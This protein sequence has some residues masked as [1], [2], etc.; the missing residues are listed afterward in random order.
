MV[1]TRAFLPR[2]SADL[3]VHTGDVTLDGAN[4]EGDFAM[5]AT[6]MA[7]MPAPLRVVPGN[8]DVG[9][10]GSAT[11]KPD[12]ARIARHER[13]FGATPW[14]EDR[15]GWR[16]LG[17]SSQ[18]IGAGAGPPARRADPASAR[19]PA[20][21]KVRRLVPEWPLSRV[22]ASLLGKGGEFAA[23]PALRHADH[24]RGAGAAAEADPRAR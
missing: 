1:S 18:V 6:A 24:P 19:T 13:H 3:I 23:V 22:M 15:P 8:H 9:D 2:L 20:R 5:A 11:E 16:L 12:A 7:D 21:R 10:L 14:V 4:G 17:L